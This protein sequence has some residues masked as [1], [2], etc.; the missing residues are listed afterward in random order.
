IK[1]ISLNVSL[2]DENNEK[3]S[4]FLREMNPDIACLQEAS[5]HVDSTA[6]ENYISKTAVDK[7]L[8]QLTDSFFA[9]GWAL[10]DFRQRNFHGKALFEHDFGGIIEYGNYIKT[11]FKILKGMSM[12]VQGNLSYISDWE[13]FGNH[14]G[15]EPRTVQV[16]DL[17][18]GKKKIRI[19]NYHGIWSKDKQGTERTKAACKFLNKIAS[20]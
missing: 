11:K 13:T 9:P 12:F 6:F 3:L 5:R 17:L 7:A 4:Q 1:L 8:P 19:M 18:V 14:P 2:F 20:E 16:V 10:K 15:E